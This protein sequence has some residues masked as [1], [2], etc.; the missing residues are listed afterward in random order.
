MNKILIAAKNKNINANKIF[1][2]IEATLGFFF[3]NRKIG[4]SINDAAAKIINGYKK[5]SQNDSFLI[6]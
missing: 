3:P 5:P 4:V 2:I 1:K 6:K